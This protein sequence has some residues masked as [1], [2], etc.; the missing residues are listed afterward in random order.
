[1]SLLTDII[2]IRIKDSEKG[3]LKIQMIFMIEIK[4]QIRSDLGVSDL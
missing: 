1:V 4:K 2:L 3:I